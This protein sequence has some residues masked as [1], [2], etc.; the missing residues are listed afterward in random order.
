MEIYTYRMDEKLVNLMPDYTE[1]TVAN[2]SWSTKF[3]IKLQD[4]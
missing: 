1:D 2:F 4:N 3:F